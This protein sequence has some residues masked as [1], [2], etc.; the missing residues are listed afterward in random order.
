MGE[1]PTNKGWSLIRELLVHPVSTTL[2]ESTD[3]QMNLTIFREIFIKPLSLI[4][5]YTMAG[6]QL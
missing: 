4:P 5:F 2:A 3:T 1:G 6:V